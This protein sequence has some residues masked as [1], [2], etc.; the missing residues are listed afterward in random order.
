MSE[1]TQSR[2]QL[3]SVARPSRTVW[4]AAA[5]A[6]AATIAVVLIFTLGG[7]SS[8]STTPVSAQSHPSLRSDGGPE[9]SGIAATIGSGAESGPDESRIAAYVSGH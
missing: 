4:L 2:A 7:E 6:L 9:E 3:P 5:L 1:A 8:K